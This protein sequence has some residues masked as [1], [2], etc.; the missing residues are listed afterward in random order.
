MKTETIICDKCKSAI[1]KEKCD[2]CDCDLCNGYCINKQEIF[3]DAQAQAKIITLHLC[4]NCK[5][6]LYWK[7]E[8]TPDL[9]AII[10]ER[11]KARIMLNSVEK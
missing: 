6:S 10:L 8:L 11:I 1:A 3:A 9:K 4:S 5:R 2:I 7:G